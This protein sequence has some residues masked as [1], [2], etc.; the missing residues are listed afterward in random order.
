MYK[1]RMIDEERK[2]QENKYRLENDK[3]IKKQSAVRKTK[4][5]IGIAMDVSPLLGRVAALR[6][7]DFYGYSDIEKC[8]YSMKIE[9]DLLVVEV[10]TGISC[11]DENCKRNA[12]QLFSEF[13]EEIKVGTLVV[14]EKGGIFI[15]R[16]QEIG[17]EPVELDIIYSMREKLFGILTRTRDSLKKLASGQIVYLK[18]LII[19]YEREEINDL[20]KSIQEKLSSRFIPDIHTDDI[21]K[22]TILGYDDDDEDDDE[23]DDDLD[24]ILGDDND[25]VWLDLDDDFEKDVPF[26]GVPG[27]ITPPRIPTF[28]EFMKE[29]L[30]QK[31]KKEQEERIEKAKEE[32]I[33]Q[34]L[35]G[36]AADEK[37]NE[38]D[39]KTADEEK[40]TTDDKK[41]D[42]DGQI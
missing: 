9:E 28:E 18:Q 12:L 41:D 3:E 21:K 8:Y 4:E 23:E 42:E 22:N 40:K 19:D 6:S 31:K 1:K 10:A 7:N 5:N 32:Q 30:Q 17:Q 20:K 27:R 2:Y 11:I 24:E 35:E 33:R 15:R 36:N 25:D 16:V 37:P 38:E 29:H 39:K 13:N 14:D 26:A 34:F